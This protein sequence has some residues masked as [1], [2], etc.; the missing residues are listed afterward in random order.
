MAPKLTNEIVVAMRASA[1]K[2]RDIEEIRLRKRQARASG[3]GV[4]RQ[5]SILP[6]T[7]GSVA[8]DPSDK[9][10]TKKEAKKQKETKVNEAANHAAANTTTAQFLGGGGGLFGKKKKYSWMTG[11][12]PGSSGASTPGRINTAP[13]GASN[14]GPVNAPPQ[15]LTAEGARRLGTW[16]EDGAKGAG[17]QMRDW[18]TVLE[19]DGHE[20]KALQKAYLG[21][22]KFD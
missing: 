5:N 13:S 4:S 12:G 18:V 2:E 3:E 22:D 15:A 11:G 10:L 14:G 9:S 20:K 21:L 7:P 8:P 1:G 16:R 17:I 19:E 6:G